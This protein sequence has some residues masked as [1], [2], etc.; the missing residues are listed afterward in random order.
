MNLSEKVRKWQIQ[1]IIKEKIYYSIWETD[2]EGTDTLLI[3]ENKKFLVIESIDTL[4]NTAYQKYKD[5]P[6]ILIK[7]WV[8]RLTELESK[9][10]YNFDHISTILANRNT[11]TKEQYYDVFTIVHLVS[12]YAYQTKNKYLIS[13]YES[14]EVSSFLENSYD[15]FGFKAE[16]SKNIEKIIF[17]SGDWGKV[18]NKLN[19]L[20]TYFEK[21]CIALLN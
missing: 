20:F 7:N 9:A 17:K 15:L 12:D 1:F 4:K 16:E 6:G 3:D 19:L 10:S 11:L 5:S 8:G 13:L 21:N 14:S 2:E 18:I